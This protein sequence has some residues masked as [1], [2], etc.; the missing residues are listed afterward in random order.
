MHICAKPFSKNSTYQS[1]TRRQGE[2][3]A[4]RLMVL[5]NWRRGGNVAS[6]VKEEIPADFLVSLVD[7]PTQLRK[8]SATGY[9]YDE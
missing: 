3:T 1:A 2:L 7:R 8:C 5:L 9:N 4:L 6:K